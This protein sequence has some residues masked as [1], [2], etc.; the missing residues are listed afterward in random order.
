MKKVFKIATLITV[1]AFSGMA[2]ASSATETLPQDSLAKQ[3]NFSPE[4]SI[5]G[6]YAKRER[7]N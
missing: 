2:V 5:A 3:L 6:R 4:Q 7:Q 1:L